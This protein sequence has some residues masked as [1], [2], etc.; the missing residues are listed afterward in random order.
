MILKKD[1]FA[2]AKPSNGKLVF[3]QD[4][5]YNIFTNDHVIYLLTDVCMSTYKYDLY[6]YFVGI[7]LY[8]YF[9]IVCIFG[10]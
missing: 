3:F 2:I 6:A 9:G 4:V 10:Y 5:V 8:V 7:F 1:Q